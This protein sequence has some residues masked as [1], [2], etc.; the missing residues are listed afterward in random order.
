MKRVQVL[1]LWQCE[2]D[3][4]AIPY[5]FNSLQWR[6]AQTQSAH[7]V[8]AR[9]A[10]LRWRVYSRG[11]SR[12]SAG[13]HKSLIYSPTSLQWVKWIEYRNTMSCIDTHIHII[14]LGTPFQYVKKYISSAERREIVITKGRPH[15]VD[16]NLRSSL[17]TTDNLGS[18]I[19]YDLTSHS[20]RHNDGDHY[21]R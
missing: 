12:I 8:I 2:E 11:Q 10:Y 17:H 20:E 9:V 21:S 15:S 7:L 16:D 18:C 19:I 6:H 1:F 13:V 14:F 3:T 5:S 4:T